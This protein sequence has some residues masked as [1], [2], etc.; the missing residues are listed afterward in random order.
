MRFSFVREA[1]ARCRGY[2][3]GGYTLGVL[4]PRL[5]IYHGLGE[6]DGVCSSVF[7]SLSRGFVSK[8]GRYMVEGRSEHCFSVV[9]FFV[10]ARSGQASLCVLP[11]HELMTCETAVISFR[12]ER[13]L[14]GNNAVSSAW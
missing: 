5:E 9:F 13:F 12:Y 10:L 6:V 2:W 8:R 4:T 11:R 14:W 3:R 1:H 7:F